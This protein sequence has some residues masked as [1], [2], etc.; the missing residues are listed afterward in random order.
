MQIKSHVWVIRNSRQS[1]AS[2][3]S[4]STYLCPTFSIHTGQWQWP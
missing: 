2:G 1:G 3:E 4:S